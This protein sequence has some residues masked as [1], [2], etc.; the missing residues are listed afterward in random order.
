MN[1]ETWS[2]SSV[3]H[4]LKFNCNSTL[5]PGPSAHTHTVY[6]WSSPVLYVCVRVRVCVWCPVQCLLL[7]F[8]YWPP[9]VFVIL[10][11]HTVSDKARKRVWTQDVEL[12]L[13]QHESS[14]SHGG[15]AITQVAAAW[16]H[17]GVCWQPA[18]SRS[19][20]TQQW[21]M[22]RGSKT[23]LNWTF[24]SLMKC[25]LCLTY[26]PTVNPYKYMEE[27]RAVTSL[28]GC[29]GYSAFPRLKGCS[30][31]CL[32]TSYFMSLSLCFHHFCHTDILLLLH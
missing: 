17:T 7:S 8:I 31:F 16:I 3:Y 19:H 32:C 12:T 25:T 27:K 20:W 10:S 4:C 18:V 1:R 9:E 23:V 13:G 5:N 24:D 2:N 30:I 29:G 22:L 28:G 11:T 6:R 26:V 14:L 15:A 21:K